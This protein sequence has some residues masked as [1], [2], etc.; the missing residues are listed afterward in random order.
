MNDGPHP[1]HVQPPYVQSPY[2][3]PPDARSPA[4]Q[5]PYGQTPFGPPPEAVARVR[6]WRRAAAWSIDFALVIAVAVALGAWTWTRIGALITSVPALAEK[7]AWG[8]LSSRGDVKGASVDFGLSLWG[9]ASGYVVQAF[10]ALVLIAFLYHFAALT[11]KGRT[12][13]KLALDL[14]VEPSGRDRLGKGQALA[15][16]ASAGVADVGLYALACCLLLRGDF[17]L[18]VTLWV[19]AVAVFWL[20]ALPVL[21][22]GNRTFTDRVTG[23]RVARSHLLRAAAG[24][25]AQAAQGG[26]LAL[27]RA[28]QSYAV[29]RADSPPAI[30][31]PQQP[32]APYPQAS[33]HVRIPRPEDQ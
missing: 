16:A 17:V 10:A 6:V 4:L 3:Q 5:T 14:R 11:W 1:P 7:S 27:E 18:S 24:Q 13:G 20:N 28:R 8:L 26:R 22:P 12:L 31:P 25:A 33:P 9:T 32:Y 19:L 30:A 21:F 15:R 2:V 23:T 29:R